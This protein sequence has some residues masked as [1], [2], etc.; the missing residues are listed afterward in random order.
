[1]IRPNTVEFFR[2]RLSFSSDSLVVIPSYWEEREK[3]LVRLATVRWDVV[4]CGG[5]GRGGG[6]R[7]GGAGGEVATGR[8]EDSGEEAGSESVAGGGEVGGGGRVA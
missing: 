1:M 3:D 8:W 6:G 7:R 4:V 2:D 5:G